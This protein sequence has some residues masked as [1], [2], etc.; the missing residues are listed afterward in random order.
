MV[1]TQS[2]YLRNHRPQP[3]KIF[4]SYCVLASVD[5]KTPWSV[6]F[7]VTTTLL[8]LSLSF[9]LHLPLLFCLTEHEQRR[10]LD[11]SSSQ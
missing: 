4:I 7:V 5:R 3:R 11:K 8:R 10:P 6:T 1:G 9:S 2:R